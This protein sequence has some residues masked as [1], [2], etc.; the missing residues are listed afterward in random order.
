MIYTVCVPLVGEVYVQVKADNEQDAIGLAVQIA[1]ELETSRTDKTNEIV[2]YTHYSVEKVLQG[3]TSLID[4]VEA[5]I[6]DV[7]DEV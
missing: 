4:T 5:N 6:Y 2:D 7:N 3:N 1:N